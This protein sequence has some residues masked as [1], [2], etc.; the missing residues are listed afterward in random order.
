MELIHV[1]ASSEILDFHGY[2]C[3]EFNKH[4]TMAVPMYHTL[5]HSLQGAEDLTL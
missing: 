5:C 1:A 3:T 4:M 2:R